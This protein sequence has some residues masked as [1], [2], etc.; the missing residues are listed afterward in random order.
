MPPMFQQ[1]L[2]K[3]YQLFQLRPSMERYQRAM[4]R[5]MTRIASPQQLRAGSSSSS[6]LVN[7]SKSLLT[8]KTLSCPNGTPQNPTSLTG[9]LTATLDNPRTAKE[10]RRPKEQDASKFIAGDDSQLIIGGDGGYA[11]CLLD[12]LEE[13]NSE[14][15]DTFRSNPLCKGDFQIQSLEVWGIQNSAYLSHS[16]P[17]Q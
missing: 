17:S 14:P 12:N 15:C 16:F 2:T 1:V 3:I 9:P 13:G 4:I 6:Q 10:A 11:L 7:S 5:I 8:T